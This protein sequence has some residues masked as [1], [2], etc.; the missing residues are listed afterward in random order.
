MKECRRHLTDTQKIVNE[1]IHCNSFIQQQCNIISQTLLWQIENKKIYDLDAFEVSQSRHQEGVRKRLVTSFEAILQILTATF[2][3]FK[4]DG[5]AVYSNWVKYVDG[6]DYKIEQAL[7]ITVK[8]SLSEVSKAINGE[9]KRDSGGAEIHPL[10]KVNVVLEQQKVEFSPSFTKLQESVNK[11]AKDM[12]SSISVIPRLTHKLTPDFAT[13]SSKFFDIINSEEDTL[14][15]FVNIQSGM[16]SNAAKCQVYLRNW[17]TY[18]EIW[19][20]NKDAFIRRYAKLKPALTTFDADINRYSEVAN[21][22]QKEETLTNINFVR[23]DCYLLKHAL[24]SHCSAWQNK[25][26]T[27]LNQNAITELKTLFDMFQKTTIQLETPPKDLDHLS[28]GLVLLQQLQADIPK[29]EAQFT[30][31]NEMYAILANYEVPIKEDE[32]QKLEQ[33][34]SAW[35]SFKQSMTVSESL[36]QEAKVKFKNELLASAEDYTK[37]VASIKDEFLAKG[38]FSASI[39]VEKALKS[40]AD[41]R[42]MLSTASSQEKTLKKGLAVFKIDHSPSKEM[43]VVNNDL[44]LINQVWLAFQEWSASYNVWRNKHFFSLDAYE[45]DDVVQKFIKR[46]NKLG[47]EVKDWEVFSNLKDRVNQTKRTVPLLLDLRN[48]A[49]RERHWNAIMDEIGKTFSTLNEDFTLDKILE[50]GLD[51]HAETISALSVAASKELSIEQGI[52]SIDTAWKDIEI[53]IAPYKEEKGYWKVK[54]AE[55]IFELLEDNQVT[56]STMKASKFFKAFEAQV[57]MWERNLSLIVEIIETLLLVQK[58]WMYLENIFVGTEDIRKQLPKES[59]VFDTVN[60]GFKAIMNGI[61]KKRNVLHIIQTPNLLDNLLEMNVQLE[62]IQKSLDMYLETKRQSFPR[63]YFLSNDDLLEILGQAKDPNS[64][65]PHLKKCF[66]NLHKLELVMA[67][68]DGRRHNEAIGMHSGDGEY[69]AFSAPVIV[70][71]PVEIWLIDI[72]NMMVLTLRKLMGGCLSNLKK[73][74][75]D[76]WLKD[77]AGMLLITAG[78]V[79]W[80]SDCTKALQEIEKGDKLAM[81]NLK[82]KQISGLKKFADL[83]RMP[84]SKL[85]RKKLIALITI[86]VHSRDVIEKMIKSNCSTVTA[87]EWLSQLRFYWEKVKEEDDC[88]IRQINTYFKFGYEYLGN[89]G[90]LVITPLTDRCYM[91]LTT[92]LHLFRGGSPQGPAGT[93]KTETVKDL[94]KGLGKYVIV[95]N[96]SD[97]LDYKSI[98]R[99]FSGIVQTGAWGCFDEFNRIDIEVLSVVA[100]QISCILTAISRKATQFVF[101]GKE[102]RLN[103]S[104]GIFIT[105]N[106]GYAGRV[107]LPDNLKSLFRPVSMMVPDTALIAEIMLF[108]EGFSNT[109]SLAKKADTLYKLAVQQLSKQDHYDFGLRALTTALRSAG[110]KKR[111]DP[112]V[113]DDVVLFMAMRDNNIPKLTAEDVPLFSAILS[114]LFPG[115]EGVQQDYNVM[116]NA[117][118]EEMKLSAIQPI[119]STFLKVIQL[120]ETKCSRH[121]VMIVG[122]TGSG[123]STAWKLLQSSMNNLS[124]THPEQYVSVKSFPINPKALSLTELYGEFNISTNEWTDGVLSTVMRNACSDEKKDQKWLVLDGPVDTLWIES[125][126]TVLDDNKVLTLI[127]GERIA[128][129]EQVSLLF[130]VES[131]S[132]ASPA[133]VSRCGMIFTDYENLGWKPYFDSWI[134]TRD[135]KN[136]VDQIKRLSEKYLPQLLNFR[137]NCS[138]LVPVPESAIIKSFCT[139]FD[140][141]ATLEN[142]VDPEEG[143]SYPKMIE[144]W[145]LFAIIWGLG[146][147]LTSESRKRFDSFLREIEGQ[148][149]SKDTVFEYHVDKANKGWAPWEDKLPT[150]WRYSTSIP[151]YKIFVPTIDTIRNEFIFRAFVNKKKPVLLVGDVGAGKTAMAHNSLF[152]S[153]APFSVLLI[154]MSAQTSSNGV[155][156]ILEGRLEKRTKNVYVPVGGKAMLTFIDDFNMPMKDTFGSQPPLEFV[157]H[158]MDYGFAYDRQKQGVKIFNDILLAGAMGPPVRIN[159]LPLLTLLGWWSKCS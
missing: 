89:S 124:K 112:T 111:Q 54:T 16:S 99:M 70:E 20:I 137:R 153:E 2:E 6:V 18:R 43:E 37:Y 50:L 45:I 57:D 74:K 40:V 24:V 135:D 83:V 29:I 146:G 144:L 41:Y 139:L 132:T 85:D 126:N 35:V 67:G 39:G 106:P 58:Q 7:R 154:N 101:E 156:N 152:G 32:K 48:P 150:G 134:S 64:I 138:Q 145:F 75:K 84:I 82:K 38:P 93:G 122:A 56:L 33:L 151:Y 147:S 157:K 88:V 131:L 123:K 9:G 92:A 107:E 22:A 76:K 21:N 96:C 62:K 116:R 27:L 95:F 73:S 31:I 17:D 13:N 23:L 110:S 5:P 14:K 87:F 47:K 104:A 34:P 63:F 78:L 1:F 109:R 77:W 68:V 125:M 117:I 52:Q 115:V 143:D 69:V 130:E 102:I 11:V 148:F 127:N 79:Q 66:D 8:K 142:G 86:E 129:P 121:G 19:E 97:A 28:D 155:Q 25:L 10:F 81:K 4:A 159:F 128:L 59:G 12:I 136:S 44:E 100:L 30:P 105:M 61:Q 55:P 71:G 51:Q 158:F 103:C 72:E 140:C 3:I 98:G 49:M 60:T 46:L 108:A 119:E 118:A 65:Q 114:D 53:E 42:K 149:P 36:L 91:T 80:T 15:I 133:T 94:G 90:R 141:V 26:T 113:P 120:Y